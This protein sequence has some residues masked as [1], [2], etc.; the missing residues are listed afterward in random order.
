VIEQL[1]PYHP[2]LAVLGVGL[3]AASLLV[4][5][6]SSLGRIRWSALE[7]APLAAA[8]WLAFLGH[9]PTRAALAVV[10][11]VVARRVGV[12]STTADAPAT[13]GRQPLAWALVVLA[14]GAA[15][16]ARPGQTLA[17]ALT[18]AATVLGAAWLEGARRSVPT[19]AVALIGA[20]L[21]GT[22]LGGPDT[23][24]AVLTAACVP[25]ALAGA[26]WVDERPPHATASTA[27][28]GVWALLPSIVLA[29][30][31]AADAYRGR[32]AGLP[33]ALVASAALV[34]ATAWRGPGRWWLLPMLLVPLATARTLGLAR[35]VAMA[36]W[37]LAAALSL[38]LVLGGLAAGRAEA[39]GAPARTRPG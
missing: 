30:N 16:T 13:N 18:I 36:S 17:A 38:A 27:A 22:F 33:A 14:A 11:A 3:G 39:S 24:A 29:A 19:S 34:A 7:V 35:E 26:R 9:L 37:G 2:E 5:R 28:S 32:P 8:S 25:L 21:V 10:L 4:H 1:D 12:R 20:S 31:V 23:E 6:W 15:A